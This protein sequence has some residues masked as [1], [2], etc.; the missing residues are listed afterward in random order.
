MIHFSVQHHGRDW[1]H[2]R[3]LAGALARAG[4]S[5][6]VAL[7]AP[8]ADVAELA[9]LLQGVAPV[10]QS[11]PV[12]WAGPSVMTQMRDALL[13]ALDQPGWTWFMNLSGSCIPLLAPEHM[14]A[15]LAT[16]Q[17]LEGWHSYHTV[18]P[19]RRPE[20]WL[21][22]RGPGSGAAHALARIQVH[23]DAAVEALLG[24]PEGFNPMAAIEWRRTLHCQEQVSEAG[25]ALLLRGLS[26]P[27]RADREAFWRAHPHVIGRQWVTLH[28]SVVEWLVAAPE[29]REVATLLAQTFLPD[30]AFFQTALAA[31]PAAL[32]QGL[33]QRDHQRVK[34]GAPPTRSAEALRAQAQAGA[35]FARKAKGDL[36][37]LHRSLPEQVWPM[38]DAH[39]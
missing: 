7:D 15:R 3:W 38:A 31:A 11:L 20:V 6:D 29:V 39:P 28:R 13:H 23:A 26:R 27:E 9:G 4:G 2:L 14:A 37:A 33:H 19:V 18:F 32:R 30:E 12:I 8:A 21:D 5:I 22:H 35:L 36:A 24:Q 16:R 1:T 10:R 34:L 25:K 17:R